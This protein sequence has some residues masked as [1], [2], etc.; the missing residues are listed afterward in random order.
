MMTRS[1]EPAPA[2]APVVPVPLAAEAE[3]PIA[4]MSAT[5]SRRIMRGA[6]GMYPKSPATPSTMVPCAIA[7]PNDASIALHERVGFRPL[8]TFGEV[9]RKFGKYWDVR[10]YERSVVSGRP[11]A[12]DGRRSAVNL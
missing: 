3:T 7:L 6:T 4:R 12:V 8:G 1:T 9:G 11:S 5:P 2:N 10:W